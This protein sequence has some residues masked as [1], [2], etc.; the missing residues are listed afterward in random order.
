[1][2]SIQIPGYNYGMETVPKSPISLE[3]FELL[4][5]SV[6]FTEEDE[7]YLRLAAKY[8]LIK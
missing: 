5:K 7:T 2:S 3:D 4:K 1:M 8:W 6:L